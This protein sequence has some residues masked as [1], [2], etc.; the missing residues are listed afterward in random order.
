MMHELHCDEP[1]YSFIKNGIKP[2]EGRKNSP[3]YQNVKVGDLIKFTYANDHFLVRVS[4]IKKYDSL[5]EYLNDVTLEKALPGV[6]SL[7]DA[8]R[9]YHQWSTPQEISQFGFL[10]IFV[11]KL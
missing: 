1:W 3:K 10:G 8:C 5:E 11:K 9:I 6:T 2:V 7:A 4:E